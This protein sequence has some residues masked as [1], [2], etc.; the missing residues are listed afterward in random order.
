MASAHIR[1]S[2]LAEMDGVLNNSSLMDVGSG[3]GAARGAGGE[4][5]SG[6]MKV[7]E[8]GKQRTPL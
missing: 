6:G 7:G 1:R 3:A 2:R 4:T 5:H 8:L